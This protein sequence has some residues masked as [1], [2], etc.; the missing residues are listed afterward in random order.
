MST[1]D[2]TESTR[3]TAAVVR[4]TAEESLD[5]PTPCEDMPVRLML[6]HLHGLA[7]AFRDAARKIGGPTTNTPPDA[8]ALALTEDW[9]ELIPARL[10]ELAAAWNEPDAW[11][12]MTMAG[13]ITLPAGEAGLVALDEV[14]LHGW[15]LAVATGQDYAVEPGALDAVE[16]FCSAIPDDPAARNG[17]FGP[18]VAVAQ[19]A[20]A[21]DRVLG[22]AGRDPRWRPG[23]PRR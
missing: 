20:G 1:I 8:G 7:I 12:G 19:D 18:R 9:R 5:E 23:P 3:R 13:G 10:E 4:G 17:L 6:A 22:L 11:E 16:A 21:L 2:L 14:V 15:D